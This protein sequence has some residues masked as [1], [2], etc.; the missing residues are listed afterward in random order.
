MSV[1][2]FGGGLPGGQVIGATDYRGTYPTR[3]AYRAECILAHMY[4]HLGIDPATTVN[5]QAGRPHSLLPIH[6]PIR[7][8]V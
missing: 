1:I 3:G 4:R 5:D 6:D 8:L 7:E 2:L